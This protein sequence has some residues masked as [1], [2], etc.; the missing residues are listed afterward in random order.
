MEGYPYTKKE[1]SRV[2]R[3][4]LYEEVWAEPMTTVALKYKVSSSF[5]AR[6]CTRIKVPRPPR[7]YWA[8][9]ATGKRPKRPPLPDACPGDELEWARNG[10]YARIAQLPPPQVPQDG[11]STKHQ[12]RSLPQQ[13]TLL[14]GFK[15]HMS[16]TGESH[17]GF[18]KPRKCLLA[19][20]IASKETLDRAIDVAN[21]LYLSFERRGHSVMLAPY[22]QNLSRHTVDEREKCGR[23][24]E[25][26]YTDLWSPARPTVAFIGTVAFGV[27]VFEMS[28]KVEA[29]YQDGKY[30]RV[31]ELP[32]KKPKRFESYSWRSTHDLPSRRLCVQVFSPYRRVAWMR[33]WRESKAGEFP[34]KLAGLVKEL[35][36]EA[37]N[38]VKRFEEGERQAEIERQRRE[39][40][41]R[42]QAREEAERRRLKAIKDS[43]EEL[44]S[45]ISAWAKTKR[46][47]E[48]FADAERRAV[49]LSDDEKRMVLE[50]LKLAREMVGGTDAL[51]WFQSWR[52]PDER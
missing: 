7:G 4:K 21:F 8:M 52:S 29:Q 39:E 12:R 44:S 20:V 13:H 51:E 50:R 27:T 28:E 1:E 36:A 24:N 9:F 48:F 41:Q 31:S 35:E 17:Y 47:E 32:S 34:R 43:R 22:G 15:E 5:L 3:E 14:E 26:Y 45:I 33:Q 46:I 18:L 42:T 11:S 25:Q 23:R 30:T 37:A 19:D 49:D 2:S 10:G 40:A 16:G 38:I 6:I